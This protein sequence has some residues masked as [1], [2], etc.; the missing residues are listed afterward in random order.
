MPRPYLGVKQFNARLHP[1]IHE[2]IREVARLRSKVKKCTFSKAA[3]D[4]IEAGLEKI[5]AHL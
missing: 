1:T 2:R 3:R 5:E 4:V